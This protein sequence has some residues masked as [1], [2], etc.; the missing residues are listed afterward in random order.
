MKSHWF[1]CDFSSSGA[2]KAAFPGTGCHEGGS[3]RSSEAGQTS[4]VGLRNR[5]LQGSG[6]S[7]PGALERGCHGFAHKSGARHYAGFVFSHTGPNNAGK[8]PPQCA[9]LDSVAGFQEDG[10]GAR[11]QLWNQVSVMKGNPTPRRF[12]KSIAGESR[13]TTR[14]GQI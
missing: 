5:I 12:T 3:P 11:P 7:G 6:E 2:F 13:L 1:F 14:G 4:K 8:M 10:A 9:F